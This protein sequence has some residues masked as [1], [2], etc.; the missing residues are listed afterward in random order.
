MYARQRKLFTSPALN[1]VNEHL[2]LNAIRY[3]KRVDAHSR[4]IAVSVNAVLLVT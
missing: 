3:A 2:M 1:V 4:Q